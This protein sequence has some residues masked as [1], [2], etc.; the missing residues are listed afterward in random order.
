VLGSSWPSRCSPSPACPRCSG[1]S[2]KQQG[3]ICAMHVASLC[4]KC[5]RCFILMLKVFH[6]DVAKSRS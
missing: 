4:F 3:D 1:T 2:F 6:L 5:F